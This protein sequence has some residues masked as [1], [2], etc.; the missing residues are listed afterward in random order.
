MT[1]LALCVVILAGAPAQPLTDIDGVVAFARAADDYA[2]MHRRLERRLPVLE[3]NANPE[4]IRRAVDAMAAAI[5]AARPDARRGDV[6]N[7]RAQAAI[8]VRMTRALRSN[9]LTPADV[10]AAAIAD[11]ADPRDTEL[12]VNGQFPW[13]LSTGMLPCLLEALPPLPPEL[14][15]RLVGRDLVLVDVHASLIVDFIRG[16]LDEA[17]TADN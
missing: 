16:V 5:R 8:R 11:G 10:W 9:G 2:F 17:A 12:M 7:A 1:A 3:V 14:Q 13:A 15:Y 6:F 4:T